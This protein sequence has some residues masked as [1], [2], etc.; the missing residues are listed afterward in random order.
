MPTFDMETG[1][2][3]TATNGHLRPNE[4]VLFHGSLS[5]FNSSYSLPENSILDRSGFLGGGT[6]GRDQWLRTSFF[7]LAESSF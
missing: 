7:Q 4:F 5:L 1:F 2:G 6:G 3:L